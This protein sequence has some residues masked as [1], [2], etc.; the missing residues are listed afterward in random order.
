MSPINAEPTARRS[1]NFPLLI[2]TGGYFAAEFGGQAIANGRVQ[3]FRWSRLDPR[4]YYFCGEGAFSSHRSVNTT[5]T[6][7]YPFPSLR[8]RPRAGNNDA[9]GVAIKTFSLASLDS[10]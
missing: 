3:Q 8:K 9:C 2:H 1:I 7:L 6:Q 10:N 4:H 5:G